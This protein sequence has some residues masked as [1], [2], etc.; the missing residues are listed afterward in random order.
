MKREKQEYLK[1]N[2]QTYMLRRYVTKEEMELF[3]T[4]R[5]SNNYYFKKKG[6]VW[7]FYVKNQTASGPTI[8]KYHPNYRNRTYKQ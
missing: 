3:K 5:G 4:H 8:S 7:G 2:Y 1:F 6:K